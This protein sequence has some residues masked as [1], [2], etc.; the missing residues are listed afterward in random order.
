MASNKLGRGLASLIAEMS[1]LQS[2][3]VKTYD[4][5][6]NLVAGVTEVSISEIKPNP[7]QPRKT[8]DENALAELATSIRNHGI[9]QPLVITPTN[10][11]YEIIAGERRFRAAKMAG[12]TSVPVII[13][14]VDE[15]TRREIALVENI[16]R[17]DLNPMEEA[18]A[19]YVLLKENDL[20]QEELAKVLGKSR[21]AVANA[22]RLLT[23]QKSVQ[24]YVRKG[25]L[26]VGHAKV[27]LAI[28][29]PKLQIEYA[30]EA[31]RKGWSVRK[32]EKKVL[33]LLVTGTPSREKIVPL[34]IRAMTDDMQRV[35]G[36]KV[37]V[38][39]NEKKG[40]I[41]IDY[42]SADD[43][44]RIYDLLEKLK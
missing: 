16:Q 7:G 31:A 21:P 15:K 34:E 8:F 6:G 18:E 41:V 40:R 4:E 24:A 14:D 44:Q 28:K 43:L 37:R 39:G 12:L 30:N 17:E 32:L 10:D 11:G 36:T 19:L 1:G 29:D 38:S 25:D 5:G 2:D 9:L 13:K 35:F 22:L 3:D 33:E 23:L 26:S 20:T 42:C 27:L